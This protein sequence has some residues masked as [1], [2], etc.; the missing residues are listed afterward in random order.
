M[1]QSE[2]QVGATLAAKPVAKYYPTG[3]LNLITIYSST[4]SHTK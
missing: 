2:H 1:S 4:C 3:G